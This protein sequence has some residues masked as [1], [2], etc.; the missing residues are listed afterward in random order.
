MALPGFPLTNFA[1]DWRNLRTPPGNITGAFAGRVALSIPR[2]KYTFLAEFQINESARA[3]AATQTDVYDYLQNGKFYAHLRTID[4]P[5]VAFKNEKMRSYNK[6]RNVPVRI[7]Y[8]PFQIGFHDDATSFVSALWKEYLTFYHETGNIGKTASM[9]GVAEEG[10]KFTSNEYMVGDSARSGQNSRPS[11][12]MK[13]RP[14][15]ARHF[16]DQIV[17]YDLGTE[18]DSVN[19][20]TFHKPMITQIEHDNY[21][22]EDKTAKM[23]MSWMLECEG[24]YFV[25]GQN[26]DTIR[27][28]L[29]YQL[30]D[31]G[32]AS[33]STS[34][35]HA[36]Q[37]TIS[38]NPDLDFFGGGGL[39]DLGLGDLGD[40]E[41]SIVPSTVPD[42]LSE[43]EPDFP[44]ENPDD[45]FGPEGPTDIPPLNTQ[46]SNNPITSDFE[47]DRAEQQY[48]QAINE[49]SELIQQRDL[50]QDALLDP[51]R[52]EDEKNR[53]RDLINR[54]NAAIDAEEQNLA[55][56]RENISRYRTRQ[57]NNPSTSDAARNTV[58][59]N[60]FF[61]TL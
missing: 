57:I 7:E 60:A 4:Y 37:R 11:L 56:A 28:I 46:N 44:V 39:N 61:D 40:L 59:N 16:F 18:P 41:S 15:R 30:G 17:I 13:L 38:M 53:I 55:R 48:E 34:S 27:S 50:A 3:T 5:R 26:R 43:G 47:L 14:S 8:Q 1:S 21:D 20:Y 35:G 31:T 12:G 42:P 25:I 54:A 23:S 32:D 24:S 33:F 2:Y 29:A 49:Q 9:Y 51:D 36:R 52:S 6:W 22:H 19:V 58:N 45:L 10:S